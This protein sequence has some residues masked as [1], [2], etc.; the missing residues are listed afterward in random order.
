MV[1]GLR[2]PSAAKPMAVV[3]WRRADVTE[4]R[5]LLLI[6]PSLKSVAYPAGISSRRRWGSQARSGGKS[7][8][9]TVGKCL[10]SQRA[11]RLIKRGW[12]YQMFVVNSEIE[13]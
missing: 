7:P 8:F 2:E 10:D 11:V 1:V 5:C 6:G 9:E 3:R 4:R 12:P 13:W